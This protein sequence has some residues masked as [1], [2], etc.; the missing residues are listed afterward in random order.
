MRVVVALWVL[1]VA[2]CHDGRVTI[3]LDVPA[4][5]AL[6]PLLD[7]DLLTLDGLVDG[8][9]VY[10]STI[11]VPERGEPLRFAEIPVRDDVW[12]ELS[13]STIAGR[14]VGF[15]RPSE[16][17]DITGGGQYDTMVHSLGRTVVM[18]GITLER[19]Q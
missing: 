17:F 2:A 19:R 14:V 16:P 8:E 18:S 13:A 1:G 7:A 11:D 6:D 4:A 3:E 12:F 9:N 10:S 15:G 5:T